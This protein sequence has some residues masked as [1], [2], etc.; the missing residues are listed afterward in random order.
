MIISNQI[1]YLKHQYE[2]LKYEEVIKLGMITLPMTLEEKRYLDALRC[3]EYVA[4]SYF[5]VGNLDSFIRIMEDYEKLCLTYGEDYNKMVFYYLLSLLN[6][7]IKNYEESVEAAKKSIKYAHHL[8]NAELLVVNY[9]N[10]SAMLLI[11]Q[12]HEKAQIAMNLAHYYKA[13]IEYPKKTIVRIYMGML[14]YYAMKQQKDLFSNTKEEFKSL[15]NNSNAYYHATI[16]LL[17]A[18]LDLYCKDLDGVVHLERACEYFMKHSYTIQLKMLKDCLG[19]FNVAHN[20]SYIN[21]LTKILLESESKGMPVKNLRCIGTEY[22][23]VDELPAVYVKYPNIISKVLIEEHVER[24]FQN[25]TEMYCLHWSFGIEKLEGLFGNLF[26]EQLLFTLSETIFKSIFEYDA[27]VIVRSKNEGE[28]IIQHISE[29]DFLQLLMEIEENLQTVLVH[30]TNEIVEMPIHFGFVHSSQ[31][32]EEERNYTSLTAH[33]DASLYYAKS[34]GQ[35][36][37]YS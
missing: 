6:F 8:K 31:L 10:I 36:C 30:S 18:Y 28:A 16:E 2:Q 12:H 26:L 7:I 21:E 23:F 29:N 37:I 34:N 9:T 15:I 25:Q 1:E 14:Y 3:Y 35:F 13:K 17:E 24:A 4:S 20:F 11:L 5:E 32:S 27:E 19:R 33:A 22:F